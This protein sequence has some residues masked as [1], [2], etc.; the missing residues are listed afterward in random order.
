MP[1]GTLSMKTSF[2]PAAAAALYADAVA[3]GS[4]GIE[5]MMSGFFVI[6]V[7]SCET[8]MLGL[9]F[10]SVLAMSLIPS[11]RELALQ[12]RDLGRRPV[13]AAVVHD[14]RGGRVLGLDRRDVI[15]RQV[16]RRRRDPP[17]RRAGP[18]SAQRPC[19]WRRGRPPPSS[20]RG[21]W[22]SPPPAPLVEL[23][24]ARPASRAPVAAMTAT[25]RLINILQ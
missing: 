10:A 25:V 24:P 21:C 4:A 18:C 19:P 13:V 8:C 7:C 1:F 11:L 17:S 23:Q 22:H 14:D 20:R 6:T 3:T 2:A 15:G 16:R 12:P 5:T 9:K